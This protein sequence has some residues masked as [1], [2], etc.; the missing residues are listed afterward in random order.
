MTFAQGAIFA[1]IIAMM[2]MFVWG[3]WRYDLVAGLALLS[4][5]A[6]GGVAPDKAFVGFANDIVIIIAAALVVSAAVAKSGAVDTILMRIA[7]RL[8]SE[9]SLVAAL[10]ITVT[11]MSAFVKNIGALALLLPVAF[12]LARKSETPPALLLMPM[13]FGALLGGIVT[14][15][16]TSPNIIVSKIREETTG[17]P[18]QMFDFAP[19][20]VCVAAAG[21]VYLVFAYRLL[22]AHRK[23]VQAGEMSFDITDYTT[24]AEISEKSPYVG[25]TL[26]DLDAAEPEAEIAGVIRGGSRHRRPPRSFRLAAGDVILLQGDPSA[27]ER[28]VAQTQLTLVRQDK[29][30]I[31]AEGDDEI[32]VVEAVIMPDSILSGMSAEQIRLFDRYDVN[33]L[34]ISRRGQRLTNRL[35]SVPL[36]AGDVIVIQ[37]NLNRLSDTLAELDCLPLAERNLGLGRQRRAW[38][39]VGILAA[40]MIAAGS[41]TVPV[42]IAF[43]AAAVLMIVSGALTLREAYAAIDWPIVVMLGALIPVSDAVRTTGGTE[44]IANALASIAQSLP[45]TGALALILVSAMAATPFLNN[46]ATVLMMGP[47]AATFA[48]QLNYNVDPFLMAV[49]LGAAC[50]FLTPFGHQCNTLVLGPGGYKMQDYV[51]FGL[52]LSVVVIVV[53]VLAISVFWPMSR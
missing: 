11:V 3:R 38:L 13:S 5:I 52:P 23:S 42:A 12:Q 53:G 20:G 36:R 7:P 2:A 28:Y 43:F 37:G 1:I 51:R 22:P 10:V 25:K 31:A 44:L 8:D 21:M 19:V 32:G 34:A 26:A 48:T 45:P 15:I 46:A 39:P 18:Y 47:V 24:E 6:V 29:D 9:R 33:L 40:A 17:Q 49:A 14:L 50:D 35:R 41:G 27:L 16:G 4:A 30:E